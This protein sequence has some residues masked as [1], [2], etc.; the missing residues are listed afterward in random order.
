[1]KRNNINRRRGSG[2]DADLQVK[3]S[4]DTTQADN[5]QTAVFVSP[6]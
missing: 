1:M 4:A 2:A 6:K 5:L 3:I